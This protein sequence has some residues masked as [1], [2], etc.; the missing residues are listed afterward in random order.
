[1]KKNLLEEFKLLE[2]GLRK[3]AGAQTALAA[4][5]RAEVEAALLKVAQTR[6]ALNRL[7]EEYIDLSSVELTGSDLASNR[8]FWD[9][10]PSGRL[11][12]EA[13]ERLVKKNRGVLNSLYRAS[14]TIHGITKFSDDEMRFAQE[15]GDHF[16]QHKRTW[17][18]FKSLL[19][20][21]RPL[22]AKTKPWTVAAVRDFFALLRRHKLVQI[23]EYELPQGGGVREP[24]DVDR[25]IDKCRRKEIPDDRFFEVRYELADNRS[26]GLITGSWFEAY[27]Y[28]VC[29]DMIERQSID[30]E[31]YSRVAYSASHAAK[32]VSRSDF[33]LLVGLPEALMMVEC[34][35][36]R[37]SDDEAD[38]VTEKTEFVR[39]VLKSMGVPN[40]HFV[41]VYSPVDNADSADAIA[42]LQ[43]AGV[44]VVEPQGLRA[45]LREQL[46]GMAA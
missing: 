42:R 4:K 38:R 28:S 44:R 33:D 41:L 36:G 39:Q 19:P 5:A 46:V 40:H 43:E 18:L 6:E 27:S 30:F 15:I 16:D 26:V 22:R 20:D 35:S 31:I 45:H 13:L 1:M 34:K 8:E 37:L 11:V 23:V 29:R 9:E 12:D 14:V 2:D 3:Y 24:I 21:R 32:A 7:H 10:Q 25:L 17:T